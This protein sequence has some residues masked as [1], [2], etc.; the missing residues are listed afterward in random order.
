MKKQNKFNLNT[1][2]AFQSRNIMLAF[3]IF[4]TGMLAAGGVVESSNIIKSGKEINGG[5]LDKEA[6]KDAAKDIAVTVVALAVLYVLAKTMGAS[7]RQNDVAAARAV[8]RYLM[9]VRKQNPLLKKYDYILNNEMALHNIAAGLANKMTSNEL[10]ALGGIADS[11]RIHSEDVKRGS[12]NDLK[13]KS[14][15]INDVVAIIKACAERDPHFM[16]DLIRL[17]DDSA[18]TVS[19][20][21]YIAS[22]K[23]R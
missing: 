12:V 16:G 19:V 10:L 20:A 6:K 2:L 3:A 7:K 17:V 1:T 9:Q 23:V 5:K 8:R 4:C 14:E 15:A 11:L 13:Q 21:E 22:Q 18:K